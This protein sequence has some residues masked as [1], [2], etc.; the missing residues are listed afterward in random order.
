[1]TLDHT[2][3]QTITPLLSSPRTVESA[4]TSST[5][6]YPTIIGA[7]VGAVLL[8]AFCSLYGIFL[9][10]N[11]RKAVSLRMTENDDYQ[12]EEKH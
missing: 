2:H 3:V 7:C 8:I 11:R 6:N 4:S 9:Y 12:G 1:M 5:T 10:L